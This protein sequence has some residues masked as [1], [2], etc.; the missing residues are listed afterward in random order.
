MERTGRKLKPLPPEMNDEYVASDKGWPAGSF[1][2]DTDVMEIYVAGP[3]V[4]RY[5]QPK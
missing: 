2:K 1:I 3:I 4:S 5:P